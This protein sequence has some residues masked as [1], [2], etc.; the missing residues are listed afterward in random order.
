MSSV[1]VCVYLECIGGVLR[2]E[3]VFGGRLFPKKNPAV[4][5]MNEIKG[6]CVC[7]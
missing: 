6:W 1:A 4:R 7:I 3:G 2:F 5:E